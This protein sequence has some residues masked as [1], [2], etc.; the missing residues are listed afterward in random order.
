MN[1]WVLQSQTHDFRQVNT[2]QSS[3]L[4]VIGAVLWAILAGTWRPGFWP[5]KLHGATLRWPGGTKQKLLKIASPGISKSES[6]R[7]SL[8]KSPFGRRLG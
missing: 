4:T 3:F 6:R 2:P 8:I 7:Q 5:S 1:T